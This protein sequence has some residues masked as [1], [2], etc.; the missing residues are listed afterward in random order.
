MSLTN[1]TAQL[2]VESLLV[3]VPVGKSTVTID[4]TFSFGTK[5]AG[6]ILITSDCKYGDVGTLTIEHPIAG[7]VG[8]LGTV[9]LPEGNR[10]I[11]VYTESPNV[12]VPPGLIYRLVITTVDTFGRNII[13]WLLVKK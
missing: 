12:E 7:T 3:Q 5:P 6:A 13:I 2:Y 8:Q 9:H 10:E 4:K 11:S 1:F